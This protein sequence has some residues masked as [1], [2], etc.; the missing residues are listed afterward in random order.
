MLLGASALSLLGSALAGKGV[1]QTGE[2]A[3]RAGHDF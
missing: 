1:A 3:Y 2:R